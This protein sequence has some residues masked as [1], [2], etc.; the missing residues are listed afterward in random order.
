MELRN[1]LFMGLLAAGT[2]TVCVTDIPRELVATPN[3]THMI[4]LVC[5]KSYV[6]GITDALQQPADWDG[7]NT[8]LASGRFEIAAKIIRGVDAVI[9]FVPDQCKEALVADYN[10]MAALYVAAKRK[11]LHRK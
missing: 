10:K 8:L 2:I 7:F 11:S 5:A 3:E 4:G 9:K 1:V 6:K